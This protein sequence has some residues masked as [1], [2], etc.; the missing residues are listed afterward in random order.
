MADVRAYE[1]REPRVLEALKSGY[2]RFVEHVY[3]RELV[4]FYCQRDALLGRAGV[5][6]PGRRATQDLVDFAGQGV[7]RLKVEGALSTQAA[8]ETTLGDLFLLHYDAGDREVKHR[9][10]KFVQHTGCG[11]SSRQ[12]ED[13]LLVHGLRDAPHPEVGF[14]GSP[15]EA[16]ETELA[17]L[18]GCGRKDVLVCASGMN[19]FYSGFRSV[20]EV[21][22]A[23]RRTK[24]LQ[25]GWLYLDSGC[26]L[27]EFLGEG[28]S[29]DFCYDA[30]NIEAILRKIESCGDELACVVIECPT[31]P[32]VQVADLPRIAEA[33]RTCGGILMIDPTIASV[34]N[35]DV[36]PYADLLT[37]SL[38]KYAAHEGDVM[39]GALALNPES[40]HYADLV[41]RTSSY[42]QPPYPRDLARLAVQMTGAA[43]VVSGME[44]NARRLANY[45]KAHPAVQ[46]VHYAGHSNH[47][48][49][50][51]K[52]SGS[53]GSMITIELNGGIEA[54]YDAL[55]VMKGPSFGTRFTLVCPFM[56]LAH[57][58][59][60]TRPEGREFLRS[61]GID[62]DLIR[63]SV[64]TEPIEEIEEIMERALSCIH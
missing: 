33:V 15:Q 13:L 5:L 2:P 45:L 23:R 8:T 19:A 30:T 34:Y 37:T 64:G 10:R 54:F 42:Y 58:D 44:T 21:Q 16:V 25:L 41:L 24:W 7:S 55:E 61:I 9:V 35:I 46:K 11:I 17:R 47:F 40:P 49:Q 36:M 53:G 1:E 26:V 43:E 29:L 60:A 28:E 12:A 59:L 14:R 56:Y 62:P 27:K 39:I 52:S 38:T 4:G 20:R 57:Y 31:N 22:S 50:V 18:I 3:I 63:I 6:V 51:A 32:L 48:S